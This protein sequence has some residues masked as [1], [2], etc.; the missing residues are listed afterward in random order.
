ML[1]PF[2]ITSFILDFES[3]LF[4]SDIHYFLST[5]FSTQRRGDGGGGVGVY[6]DSPEYSLAMDMNEAMPMP[7]SRS[8]AVP[9]AGMPGP[10]TS[11]T[12]KIM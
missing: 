6:Y 9:M 1:R 3:K 4:F 8:E 7:M 10:G 12:T 11:L 2:F 5:Q